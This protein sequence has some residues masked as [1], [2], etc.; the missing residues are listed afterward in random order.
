M[1][2]FRVNYRQGSFALSDCCET[3]EQ[4]IAR[5]LS[6]MHRTGVWHVRV[7]EPGGHA[8]AQRMNPAANCAADGAPSPGEQKRR[9][10]GDG[11]PFARVFSP[12]RSSLLLSGCYHF[13]AGLAACSY[14]LRQ[15][16]QHSAAT[17]AS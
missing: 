14:S 5:A 11:G 6:L 8:R 13:R 9:P 4:A 16:L 1:N 15:E 17:G 10:A 3:R 12:A 2:G 7:E